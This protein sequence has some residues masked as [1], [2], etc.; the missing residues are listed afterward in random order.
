[1]KRNLRKETPSARKCSFLPFERPICPGWHTL[2]HI[3]C[4]RLVQAGIPLTT[5][6][7]LA[8]HKDYSTTLIYA[9]L[10]WTAS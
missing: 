4:S 3:F 8:G 2:R 7:K 5:V 1:M 10:S 9:H 6:Q